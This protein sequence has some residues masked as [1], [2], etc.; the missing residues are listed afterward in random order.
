MIGRI[1]HKWNGLRL[2]PKLFL[3]YLSV[4]IIPI[5]VLGI[6]S[7]WQSK[8]LL[9][10]QAE[11]ALNRNVDTMAGYFNYKAELYNHTANIILN[12][13]KI[14]QII[15]TPYM[16]YV[17]LYYD[18]NRYFYPNFNQIRI[19][20][21]E[22]N[23]LT[24]YTENDMP[25]SGYAIMSARRLPSFAWYKEL[26]Q[27]DVRPKWIRHSSELYFISTFPRLLVNGQNDIL[28]MQIDMKDLFGRVA[29]LMPGNGV[30]V[31]NAKGGVLYSNSAESVKA[32]RLND[33]N[34]MD[35]IHAE[36]G[37]VEIGDQKLLV[38][39]KQIPE[40]GWLIY[41]YV[42][43]KNVSL[44]ADKI[45]T[46]TSIVAGSCI[47]LLLILITAMSNNLMKRIH[48]LVSWMKR[49]ETGELDLQV[50]TG[51]KDE[52][53]ELMIRFGHMLKRLNEVIQESYAS[54]IIQKDAELRA[55]QA[56]INPHFLYNTLSFVNWKALRS[57]E[58]D[59]SHI[60]V[61]LSKFYRTALNKG[62][63]II[64][65]REEL[66]NIRSYLEIV[67]IMKNY[68]FDV[69]YEIDEQ[70]YSHKMINLVLQPLVENAIQHGI[71]KKEQGRGQIKLIAR[72]EAD[73]VVF[74]VEDN[75]SGI[76]EDMIGNLLTAQTS[77]YG[78]K[79]VHERLQLKFGDD[80]GITISSTIG[81]G[82]IMKVTIP[83]SVEA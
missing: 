29:E 58:H 3:S 48:T 15:S 36:S 65:V 44:N 80:Y 63:Q 70:V 73:T 2:K 57:E 64:T 8:Q 69:V 19:G 71:D 61:S 42:P 31:T 1:V 83:L 27:G 33:L 55:L 72:I 49:V 50:H 43:V 16:D 10:T 59:I 25:E 4:I 6:Y 56:Q 66:E 76:S 23:Q 32:F 7:Y 67:L 34:D 13:S 40:S 18:L 17:N 20:N 68:S 47:L 46:A 41:T 28:V 78:L 53:G 37:T 81:E 30:I 5:L 51:A 75:G 11:Q 14:Q 82:T 60:V 35:I 62:G 24:V 54:K 74:T 12:N 26:G 52:I 45:L 9:N 21:K 77:G 79:N 39:K 38:L 22:I